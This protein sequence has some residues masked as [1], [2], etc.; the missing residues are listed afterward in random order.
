M[1]KE[2]ENARKA[3][4]AL[5]DVRAVRR[6]LKMYTFGRQWEDPVTDGGG[7]VV[8]ER[9]YYEQ[10]GRQPL[11][12]N[13]LRSLVKS[14]VGRFRQMA[15]GER[16]TA[17]AAGGV[18]PSD[19]LVPGNRLEEMDARALEEFLISGCAVQK[20]S[21][22]RRF[23]GT[24]VWVDN[25]NPDRFFCNRY[26]DPRG[27]DIRLAGMLHDMSLCEMKLRFG[28]RNRRRLRDIEMAFSRSVAG[29]G[30]PGVVSMALMG[31]TTADVMWGRA[32][33]DGL[34]R[35]VEV[36]TFEDEGRGRMGWHGRF[37]T[38]D[39]TLIDETSS[40]Y[41]HAGH[42]FVVTMYP[43]TDG[44]VHPFIEDVIDQQRH[45]NKLVTTIDHILAHSAKGV[46]LY[47]H[48]ALP[49]GVNFEDIVRIWSCPGAV[50]PVNGRSQH[51]PQE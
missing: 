11:T 36:W 15:A 3:W 4:E 34:C 17:G 1:R 2:F 47:P 12:N 26:Q 29:R 32:Q 38:S 45:I 40:P 24:G 25:V 43:L 30:E 35:V 16:E 39:G 42:P 50:V 18:S 21:R 22:E 31:C 20:V 46:L 33:A 23:E 41:G 19:V 51:T 13:L 7:N 14:V 44:E 27:L 28:H 49:A 48:D 10:T 8:P 5:G 6:R 37:F 9:V